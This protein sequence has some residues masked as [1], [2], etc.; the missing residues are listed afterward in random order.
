MRRRPAAVAP[1]GGALGV[2][3]GAA[4][5]WE[6]RLAFVTFCHRTSFGE[7]SA[8]DF[9]RSHVATR[10]LRPPYYTLS[11]PCSTKHAD[12]LCAYSMGEVDPLVELGFKTFSLPCSTSLRGDG[13]LR[14]MAELF[15]WIIGEAWEGDSGP[16]HSQQHRDLLR[17]LGRRRPEGEHP[18]HARE[19]LLCPQGVPVA[20]PVRVGLSPR[21]RSS[22]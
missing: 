22:F 6:A 18:V 9:V 8:P 17:L 3:G 19:H 5:L 4:G 2:P 7:G 20:E 13:H 11:L 12:Q 16:R 10:A 14:G 15:E 21:R 1:V